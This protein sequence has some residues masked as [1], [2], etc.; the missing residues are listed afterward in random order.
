MKF[1]HLFFDLDGTLIDS[2]PGIFNS[3]YYTLEKLEIRKDYWP[4][5]LNP[6]IGPP[7]RESFKSLFGFDEDLTEKATTIYREYYSQTGMNE[8]TIYP[9]IR[10]A[11][12]QL[13]D[14]GFNLSVVTSKAEQYAIKM[15]RNAGFSEFIT[16]VSGCEING[17]RSEKAELINYTLDRLGLKP[18]KQILMIGDRYHDLR[19]ARITGISSA[20]VLYGYGSV[21]ELAAETPGITIATPIELAEKII[22]AT[23]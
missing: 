17:T 7:L 14:S 20:A 13:K 4:E 8:F 22:G 23:E 9:G 3:V 10:E 16:I 15:V 21:S 11:L 19:G 1:S 18:S 12:K 2:K 6:F 5:N